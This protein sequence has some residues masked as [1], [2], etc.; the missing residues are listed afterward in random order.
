MTRSSPVVVGLAAVAAPLVVY[1]AVRVVTNFPVSIDLV[2]PL[3]AAERW[4]SGGAVY[5]ADGF[6]DPEAIPPFLYPPFVLPLIGALT[7]LPAD[8]L[9]WVWLAAFV[10][11]AVLTC[12][13]LA[14]PW[15]L[16]PFAIAWPPFAEGVWNGN[17]QVVLFAAF[18]VTFWVSPNQHDLAIDARDL[19]DRRQT[20]PLTGFT[21]A[22]VGA[23]KVSQAFAW[24]VVARHQPRAAILGAT[25]W[26][27][28]VVATLPLTGIGL[29]RDWLGQASL[30]ADPRWP[31][32]GVPL[33][34]YLPQLVVF[35]ITA[36]SIVIALRLR[37]PDAGAWAGLLMLVVAPNLHAFTGLFAIP[38]MLLVRRE[39]ALIAVI[40]MASYTAPGWWL[41]VTLLVA[42]LALGGRFPEL[43]VS[44]AG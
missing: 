1:E 37:G 21:A 41:G 26:L 13:R 23:V 32:I 28:V 33:L 29:Y 27:V 34:L 8:M 6:R 2:I 16:V 5:L 9:R 3:Q 7:Q 39:V 17:I 18:V 22:T 25:P 11:I 4:L 30:A 31:M 10:G 36:A 15:W 19:T 43:R 35:A 24:L 44:R 42:T 38:A 12:R 20:G 40:G 14:M